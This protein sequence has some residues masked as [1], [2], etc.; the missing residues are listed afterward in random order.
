LWFD[1]ASEYVQ[2]LSAD[3]TEQVPVSGTRTMAVGQHSTV[4][5]RVCITG[6]LEPIFFLLL[7]ARVISRAESHNLMKR[8]AQGN[9]S[10]SR[11]RVR[12]AGR[13]QHRLRTTSLSHP[14]FRHHGAW[15]PLDRSLY[16]ARRNPLLGLE[17]PLAMETSMTSPAM[18]STTLKEECI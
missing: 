3:P 13:S 7:V 17:I 18:A 14:P 11:K 15:L 5:M 2:H 16:Q 8:K 9:S 12:R 4:A 10:Q 1:A 6:S